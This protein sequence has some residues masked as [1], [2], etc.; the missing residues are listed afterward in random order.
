VNGKLDVTSPEDN[1][2]PNEVRSTIASAVGGVMTEEV[3]A[4][5]GSG[6]ID[7]S[8]VRYTSGPEFGG[9]VLLSEHNKLLP[10]AI[11]R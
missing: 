10:E 8:W 11:F 1:M 9:S 7:F 4:V 3:G 6:S 5:T 2:N